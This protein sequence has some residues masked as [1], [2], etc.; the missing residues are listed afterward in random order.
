MRLTAIAKTKLNNNQYGTLQDVQADLLLMCQNAATY[1]KPKS[2]VHSDS[3][4]VR[5]VIDS[6]MSEQNTRHVKREDSPQPAPVRQTSGRTAKASPAA[7]QQ[8]Q[9]KIVEDMMA[10]VDNQ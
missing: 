3:I 4:R 6:Y 9:A 7:L 10:L 2:Q 8:E 1:N 5:N